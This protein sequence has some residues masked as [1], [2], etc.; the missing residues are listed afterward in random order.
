MTKFYTYVFRD[1]SRNNE[2]IYV[3]KGQGS[4]AKRHLS[5]RD[6]HPFTQ[7]LQKMAKEGVVPDIEIISAFDEEHA[8]FMEE[9]LIS[10][11]GRKDLGKGSLLNL[12]DGGQKAHNLGP[13]TLQ[14][15]SAKLK[16]RTRTL[17]TCERMSKN[18]NYS[19][20]ARANISAAASKPYTPERLN[21]FR[22]KRARPCSVDG[23]KTIFQTKKELANALGQGKNGTRSPNLIFFAPPLAERQPNPRISRRERIMQ[24][25]NKK[26]PAK[27]VV[28]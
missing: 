2:P 23:G 13:E 28:E 25:A 20:E 12:A 19:A 24:E 8:L 27:G 6:R 16:G 17:E 7:R 26:P 21:S 3:G 5:R 9:C 18:H 14:Y 11:F 10:L 22:E 4:R 15:M 1:P